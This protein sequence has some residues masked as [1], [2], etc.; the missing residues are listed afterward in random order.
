MPV[1][2]HTNEGCK[3]QSNALTP[4]RRTVS[5]DVSRSLQVLDP[6]QAR[7]WRQA[8]PIGQFDVA[9]AAV[10]LKLRDNS[11]INIVQ[12]DFWHDPPI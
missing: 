1:D 9:Q 12:L 5:I 4:Q 7:R 8:D 6:P 10:G 3:P 2:L 11:A